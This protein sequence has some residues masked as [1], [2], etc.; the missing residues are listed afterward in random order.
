MEAQQ[1]GIMLILVLIASGPFSHAG[2]KI[3]V[4]PPVLM[5]ACVASANQDIFFDVQSLAL[6]KKITKTIYCI[7]IFYVV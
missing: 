3:P 4:V 7:E 1:H 5:L 6:L 2:H